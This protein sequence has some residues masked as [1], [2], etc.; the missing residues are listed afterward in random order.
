MSVDVKK[1]RELK[2]ASTSVV[3][4]YAHDSSGYGPEA[5]VRGP[6]FRWFKV[7]EVAD[8]YKH[9]VSSPRDDADYCA[10]AM[11]A[12]PE[13]LDEIARLRSELDGLKVHGTLTIVPSEL[14]EELALSKSNEAMLR[15]ALEKLECV[16]TASEDGERMFS[17]CNSKHF[18]ETLMAGDRVF[19]LSYAYSDLF[20]K[21]QS[22]TSALEVIRE[23]M[24]LL[25]R[26]IDPMSSNKHHQLLSKASEILKSQF[27]GCD[28]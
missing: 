11:N 20:D 15:A 6:F 17:C 14:E 5:T 4:W 27:G 10:A 28:E 1:L 8:E 7:A 9:N 26:A 24:G 16:F 18:K 13:L 3:K 19:R 2:A 22:P 23:T 21:S 25:R 12:V